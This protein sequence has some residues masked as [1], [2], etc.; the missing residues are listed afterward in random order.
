MAEKEQV[1]YSDVVREVVESGKYFT[2]AMD[3]YFLKYY[4]AIVERTFFIMLTV[5]SAIIVITLYFT[6]NNILPLHESFP[7]L[8]RQPDSVKYISKIS[9][10]KPATMNYTSSEAVLRL[11]LIRFTREVFT[12]DYSRGNID[13]LNSKLARIKLLTT[14]DLFSYFK[15]DL[16]SLSMKMFN[17]NIKQS[18]IINTFALEDTKTNITDLKSVKD[19]T[20]YVKDYFSKPIPTEAILDCNVLLYVDNSLHSN[21]SRRIKITF[22]YTPIIF[23]VLKNSFTEPKLV[24]TNFEVLEQKKQTK[25]N[26]SNS[27]EE[28]TKENDKNDN[29]SIENNNFDANVSNDSN[30]ENNNNMENNSE[31]NN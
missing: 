24:I 27:S 13:E 30:V 1:K 10:V 3:W 21:D 19:I 26:S 17:R 20:K 5:C 22:K 15:K 8:V 12:H 31:E 4:N 9:P 23:N 16:N 14:D 6:I 2:D 25:T 18:V 11:E 7:V 29:D 28:L